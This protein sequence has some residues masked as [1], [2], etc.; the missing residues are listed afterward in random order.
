MFL[1]LQVRFLVGFNIL[2]LRRFLLIE[3][4]YSPGQQHVSHQ[5]KQM[6]L[7][8]VEQKGEHPNY[9]HSRSANHASLQS[10]FLFRQRYSE[11]V[12]WTN[13]EGCHQKG[14]GQLAATADQFA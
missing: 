12:E 8:P 14:E 5:L 11:V 6:E 3:L 10:R 7:L 9:D 13:T 1:T 4:V 2:Y